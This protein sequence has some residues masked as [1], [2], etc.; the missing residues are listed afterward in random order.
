ME[1]LKL[2][3]D[4]V[5]LCSFLKVCQP[6]QPSKILNIRKIHPGGIQ[7][8]FVVRRVLGSATLIAKLTVETSNLLPVHQGWPFISLKSFFF[9]KN[10]LTSRGTNLDLLF[11]I[12]LLFIRIFRCASSLACDIGKG[13]EWQWMPFGNKFKS[14]YHFVQPV[15]NIMILILDTKLTPYCINFAQR[16]HCDWYMSFD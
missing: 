10:A 6:F 14:F 7:P 2:C 5:C 8:P 3:S 4:I 9:F 13:T 12:C 16:R 11:C 15:G 1:V